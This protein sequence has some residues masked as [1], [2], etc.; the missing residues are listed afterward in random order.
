MTVRLSLDIYRS[1]L[2]LLEL[3]DAARM[4]E[5]VQPVCRPDADVAVGQVAYISGWGILEDSK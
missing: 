1:F 3:T 4:T 2:A 5:D